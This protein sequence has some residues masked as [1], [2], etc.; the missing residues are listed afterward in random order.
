MIFL[1]KIAVQNVDQTRL[2]NL[3]LLTK[4]KI[5]NVLNVVENSF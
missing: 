4:N 3:E 1:K 5:I 2:Q